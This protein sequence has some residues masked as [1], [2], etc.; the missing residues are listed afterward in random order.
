MKK[1]IYFF[2][3]SIF[4]CATAAVAEEAEYELGLGLMKFQYEEFSDSGVFL[5]G[6]YGFIPGAIIKRKQEHET[7]SSEW[8]TSLYGNTIDY[9]GQTQGGNPLTTRSDAIIFDTHLKLG[10]YPDAAQVRGPYIGLG[11]RYWLRN[12]RSGYDIYSNSVAGLREH[13]YWFYSLIG[14]S[15]NLSTSEDVNFGFDARYTM[16]INGKMDVDFLGYN[17]YDDTQVNLGNKAGARFVFPVQIKMQKQRLT[18][19]PYYEIINIGRSNNVPVY[20]NGVPTAIVIY[21]PRSE[22]RNVGVEVSWAW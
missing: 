21:E 10:F 9:E 16:M 14:F 20:S 13:Y 8:V 15:T 3:T 17:N 19:S 18:I 12:I 11:Y 5:D 2:I 4:F 7:F 22:T 1:I 6:E